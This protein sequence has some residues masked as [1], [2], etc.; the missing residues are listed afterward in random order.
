[1]INKFDFSESRDEREIV[2]SKYDYV[3]EFMSSF[4]MFYLNLSCRPIR[5]CRWLRGT[6]FETHGHHEGH[7]EREIEREF[8]VSDW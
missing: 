8:L 5:R 7:G 2:L 1:M 3:R 4:N 6:P